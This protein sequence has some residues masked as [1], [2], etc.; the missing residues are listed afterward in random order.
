MFNLL[1]KAYCKHEKIP[2][3]VDF[4]YCPDCGKLVYCNWYMI[5][6]ACCN[7]KREAV[8]KWGKISPVTKFC[9]NCGEKKFE[10]IKLEKLTFIDLKFAIYK[11]EIKFEPKK[12]Q[13]IFYIENILNFQQSYSCK[14]LLAEK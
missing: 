4:A 1:K 5:R 13:D 14:L 8:L 9:M 11:K 3:D 7:I 12:L 6:C 10:V 2:P